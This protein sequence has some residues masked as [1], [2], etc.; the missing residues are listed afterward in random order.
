NSEFTPHTIDTDPLG[1]HHVRFS[2]RYRNIPIWP[3]EVN[4]HLDP[5][6]NVDL[7]SG[8]YIPTP[9]ALITTPVVDERRAI[10]RAQQAVVPATTLHVTESSVALF[11]PDDHPPR[12]AWKIVFEPTL[13]S[14]W[15]VFIDAL[16]GA[17][18]K[19][20]NQVNFESSVGSGYDLVEHNRPLNTWYDG[21]NY[22]L[23]DTS[24]PMY[25]ATSTPPL[26]PQIRGAIIVSDAN[27]LPASNQPNTLPL[28]SIVN[29]TLP[30]LWNNGD[31]VSAAYNISQ[32]YDYFYQ[33]HQITTL[34]APNSSLQAVVRY[35]QGY[36]NAFWQEDL[37]MVV[38]G[39]GEPFAASL[40]IVAHELSHAVISTTARLIYEN[41]SG[42]LN[43]AF[44]DIF[45]EAV[46]A[47]TTGRSPDWRIGTGLSRPIRNLQAPAS[48]LISG[49]SRTYPA[50]MSSYI[51]SDDPLLNSFPARDHG[52]VHLNS[53][54][55]GHAFYL[56]AEGLATGGIGIE[57]ASQIFYYA[58]AYHLTPYAQFIDARLAA[59][60]A[61]ERLYGEGSFQAQQTSAAFDAVGI[62]DAPATPI[63]TP[64]ALAAGHDATL[65]VTYN[66]NSGNYHLARRTVEDD[67]Q[68]VGG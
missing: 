41:Q 55:I 26:L 35:G 33:Q 45:A 27:N 19:T 23:I 54:I 37:N 38:F 8:N 5:Q 36:P 65:F 66:R 34:G 17:V 29:S 63:P 18:L 24:K 56:L 4:V 44:A 51:A 21:T 68:G 25:D 61:A 12:L 20:I 31:A 43:E 1:R 60:N 11:A 42:A 2:Q 49:T 39:D 14:S 64:S 67:Q 58:L 48:T 59:I 16:N 40:D 7:F 6:G 47:R 62:S 52:G 9:R 10:E 46:E 57:Q 22:W 32:T 50:H 15:L 30:T 3:S 13:T 53:T 28:T